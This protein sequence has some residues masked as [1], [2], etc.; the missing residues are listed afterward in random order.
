MLATSDNNVQIE[1]TSLMPQGPTMVADEVDALEGNIKGIQRGSISSKKRQQTTENGEV[2]KHLS[3]DLT[4]TGFR[5][6]GERESHVTQRILIQRIQDRCLIQ[7]D[8][9]QSGNEV[10]SGRSTIKRRMQPRAHKALGKWTS[11]STEPSTRVN[12]APPDL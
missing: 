3:A 12:P 10:G 1:Y 6:K 9:Y 8:G 2:Q 11:H 4:M 5:S 7:R